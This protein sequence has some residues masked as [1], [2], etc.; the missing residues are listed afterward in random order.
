MNRPHGLGP[1]FMLFILYL[2][3]TSCVIQYTLLPFVLGCF[4]CCCTGTNLVCWLV[5]VY[6]QDSLSEITCARWSAYALACTNQLFC[7]SRSKSV[8]ENTLLGLLRRTSR[9]YST[10]DLK[11]F[12]CS[13]RRYKGTSDG[14][15]RCGG[16]ADCAGV[17]SCGGC[18]C[19]R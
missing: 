2:Y 7:W 17:W 1:A 10:G 12:T 15:A 11:P 5:Y 4:V 6:T 18:R 9:E 13:S 8:F 14:G 19:W 3:R 16:V